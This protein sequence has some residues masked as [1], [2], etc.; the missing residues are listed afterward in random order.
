MCNVHR[1]VPHLV[2]FYN[3]ELFC[4]YTWKLRNTRHT[5]KSFWSRILCFY[6]YLVVFNLRS[7]GSLEI[8]RRI[9]QALQRIVI[10]TLLQANV[11]CGILSFVE[12]HWCVTLCCY[13]TYFSVD[14][15]SHLYTCIFPSLHITMKHFRHT[16]WN[17]FLVDTWIPI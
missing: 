6:K 2:N 9:Q 4:S 11:L 12:N 3:Y 8:F 17:N 15:W 1:R 16:T 14:F 7:L 5:C 10:K 13:V